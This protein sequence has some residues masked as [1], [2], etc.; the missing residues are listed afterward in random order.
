[1]KTLITTLAS[2]QSWVL[3]ARASVHPAARPRTA[4]G[5]PKVDWV[6]SQPATRR[7]AAQGGLMARPFSTSFSR[8]RPMSIASCT[9]QSRANCRSALQPNLEGNL[10]AAEAIGLADDARPRRRSH[11]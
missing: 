5:A 6:G 10:K 4:A 11:Q 9:G 1:M 7:F 8:P 3:P 2:P